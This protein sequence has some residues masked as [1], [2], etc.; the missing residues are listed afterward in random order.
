MPRFDVNKALCSWFFSNSMYICSI[1]TI[2]HSTRTH[3]YNI[4]QASHVL[5]QISNRRFKQRE[6]FNSQKL[7]SQWFGESRARCQFGFEVPPDSIEWRK[8]IRNPQETNWLNLSNWLKKMRDS[9][10]IGGI[11]TRS[12]ECISN[13][14]H[15]TFS[16]DPRLICLL[17]TSNLC[18]KKSTISVRPLSELPGFFGVWK[19][20]TSELSTKGS[21]HLS[22][23]PPWV[24]SL[25][26]RP[27]D[28]VH[29][30]TPPH[31]G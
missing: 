4:I 3:I 24:L 23:R 29:K 31:P 19:G 10:C 7:I 20:T 17:C 21:L 1:P 14:N 13:P 11:W 2:T 26:L 9:F 25:P 6:T 28:F 30:C 15:K 16:K 18:C 27:I 22:W 12:L 8:H 5:L